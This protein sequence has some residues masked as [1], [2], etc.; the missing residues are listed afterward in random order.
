MSG[1]VTYDFHPLAEI[2]PLLEG[3]EFEELVADIAEH[4]LLNPIML[5]EGKILDGRNRYRACR[6]AGVEPRYVE[7]TGDSRAAAAYVLS[8]NVHRRHLDPSVR[9]MVAARMANL[10]WGQRADRVE[11]SI[12]LSTAAKLVGVS[13]PSVK[14]ATV[15][16]KHG[17]PELQEA[18]ERGRLAVH[19]AEKAARLPIEGQADFLAAVATG[20][21]PSAALN[22]LSRKTRAV[23]LAASTRA[24]PVGEKRWPLMLAD[25][26]WD[27]NAWNPES[28]NKH[29]ANHYPV[30]SHDEICALPVADLAADDC[31][32]F[33]WTTVP[34]LEEAFGVLKAWGFQYK[35]Q[36]VWDKEKPATGFWVRG[37]HEILLIATRGNPPLP[38]HET[39]ARSVIRGGRREHSRKPEESYHIIERY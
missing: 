29:V 8:Q 14:R 25:P 9:A 24:L 30:M 35:S 34:R 20:K 6:A 39:V 3:A 2:L 16:L 21:P 17:T 5:F 33:L 10:K 11:G 18:V 37:Q 19:E 12:D 38:P 26:A 28:T 22:N 31:I 13:E 15:V 1:A 4:R 27:F 32:L 7:F 23:T 36:F